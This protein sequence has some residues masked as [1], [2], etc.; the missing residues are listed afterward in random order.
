[1]T[2][3]IFVL[4]MSLVVGASYL[5]TE[6]GDFLQAKQKRELESCIMEQIELS[7]QNRS[8]Y[9][10]RMRDELL[11]GFVMKCINDKDFRKS[12]SLSPDSPSN[13]SSKRKPVRRETK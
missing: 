8:S 12:I 3:V 4:F 5:V 1:M 9:F 2:R 10:P 11:H 13:D 6:T 7:E